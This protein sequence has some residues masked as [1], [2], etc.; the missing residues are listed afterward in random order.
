MELLEKWGDVDLKGKNCGQ[1]PRG[2]IF[3]R[4]PVFVFVKPPAGNE[5]IWNN[6]TTGRWVQELLTFRNFIKE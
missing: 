2:W 3:E 4:F 5:Q 6:F 1:K